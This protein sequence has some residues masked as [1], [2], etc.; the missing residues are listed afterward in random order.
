MPDA[1]FQPGQSFS[2]Q[3]IWR[4]PAGDYVRAVFQADV[5]ELV[6]AADKYVVRLSRLLAGREDDAEGAAKQL[7]TLEGEYWD[8]VQGL[9][10]RKIT[11]AYEA[12]N[13]RPL[14][15]RLAT[16]TGEHTFFTRHQDAF[17]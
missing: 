7:E 17:E 16:L 8:R 1:R 3:L 4:L 10:G 11:I 6:P 12:D 9:V 15:L 2:L 13:G 5:E 14:Y